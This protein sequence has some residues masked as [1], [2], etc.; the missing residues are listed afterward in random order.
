MRA[1]LVWALC[2]LAGAIRTT[3]QAV[4]EYMTKGFEPPVQQ[5]EQ[6]RPPQQPQP[7]GMMGAGMM[8]FPQFPQQS[9]QQ[10]GMGF[11]LQQSSGFV[12]AQQQ[13]A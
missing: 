9:E 6:E 13:Q 1:R 10:A 5:Q 7:W 4:E 8:G 12:P 11:P 3:P 2:P